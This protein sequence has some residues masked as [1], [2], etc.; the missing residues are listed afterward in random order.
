MKKLPFPVF[1]FFFVIFFS[2]CKNELDISYS[3]SGDWYAEYA[4]QDNVA[5]GE[6]SRVVQAYHFDGNG[7]G[8]WYKFLLPADSDEPIDMYGGH[9]FGTFTYTMGDEG[10]L[11]IHLDNDI[12]G[13]ERTRQLTYGEGTMEGTDN[14]GDYALQRATEAQMLWCRYWD[15]TMNGRSEERRVGKE[16]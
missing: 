11:N 8:Y 14:D 16:C 13:T 5:N 4:A 7:T 9:V 1:V 2:S 15:E 12:N 6:Y 10:V 3:M